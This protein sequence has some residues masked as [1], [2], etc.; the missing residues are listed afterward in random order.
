MVDLEREED[1]AA[2][3][4]PRTPV[5]GVYGPGS[6]DGRELPVN[7]QRG[8]RS[9]EK[10]SWLDLPWGFFLVLAAIVV[11]AAM[12]LVTM[13]SIPN[14][15]PET[16]VGAMSGALA[17]IGTL[18]GTY[19]GIK[20]GLDGQEKLRNTRTRDVDGPGER[21]QVSTERYGGRR[22]GDQPA[23]EQERGPREDGER[24]R[25]E[26]EERQDS[27]GASV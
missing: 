2:P 18:V 26:R 1:R 27:E 9:T 14:I 17:L 23:E 16:A 12:Y 24:R 7:N 3:E 6:M 15:P 5:P 21:P 20:A 11:V 4:Q 10:R 19:F 22:W 8:D 25:G 13:R